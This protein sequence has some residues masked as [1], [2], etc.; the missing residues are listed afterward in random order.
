MDAIDL[1]IL[2]R[3]QQDAR[4]SNVELAR[5]VNLSPSPCLARV[6]ALEKDGMIARYVTLLDPKK[7]GITVSVLVQ[8]TLIVFL[9]KYRY[10]PGRQATNTHGN[11]TLEIAWTIAP[12][13]ILVVLALLSRGMWHEIKQ[14][15]PPSKYPVIVTAKQFNWDITYPGPDGQFDTADDKTIEAAAL[16][17]AAVAQ[18][19]EGKPAKKVIVVKKKL[20]NVVV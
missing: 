7:I 8:V 10:Q 3:L 12:S 1:R 14:T 4:T 18:A 5:A 16:A 6:R 9:V 19:M 20:V 13:I 15:I 17:D 2:E 11:N